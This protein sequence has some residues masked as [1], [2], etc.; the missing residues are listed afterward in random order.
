MCRKANCGAHRAPL[1]GRKGNMRRK[2]RHP[3][4]QNFRPLNVM[5]QLQKASRIWPRAWMRNS[6]SK[7][8]EGVCLLTTF[9]HAAN[10]GGKCPAF[11]DAFCLTLSV[12]SFWI[13][14]VKWTQEEQPL[15]ESPGMVEDGVFIH[16]LRSDYFRRQKAYRFKIPSLSTHYLFEPFIITGPPPA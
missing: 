11:R 1:L 7:L 8:S 12:S 14:K 16:K 6:K 15:S 4:F 13:A 2:H 9:V 10:K 5:T 3:I